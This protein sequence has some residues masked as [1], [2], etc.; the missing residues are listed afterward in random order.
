M[1]KNEKKLWEI[2]NKYC[3]SKFS[4]H[5]QDKKEEHKVITGFIEGK[6]VEELRVIESGE[7]TL[8]LDGRIHKHLT[9]SPFFAEFTVNL[10][11]AIYFYPEIIK[12]QSK[13]E[14]FNKRVVFLFHTI[15]ILLII[16]LEIYLNSTFRG[17]TQRL[18]IRLYDEKLL[19]RFLKIFNLKK[20]FLTKLIKWNSEYPLSNLLPDRMDFLQKKKCKIAYKLI[21]INVL[22]V[23][24]SIWEKIFSSTDGYIQKRHRLVHSSPENVFKVRNINQF[25]RIREI[26][27]IEN[28][29]LDIVKFVFHIEN[30]R[31]FKYPDPYEVGPLESFINMT[32]EPSIK[33]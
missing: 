4:F 32:L 5:I 18:P 13:E 12:V 14:F 26:T 10:N 22:N 19:R 16:A 3:I 2:L 28:T 31:L 17:V 7:I 23:E 6:P 25:D 21:D 8:G 30:Q 9:L 11:R 1:Y 29:I 27:E 20:I 33:K 24:N 15:H